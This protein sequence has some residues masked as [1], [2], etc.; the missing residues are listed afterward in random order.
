MGFK[1]I[2]VVILK[3]FTKRKVAFSRAFITSRY[4]PVF[5]GTNQQHLEVLGCKV[6]QSSSCCA[7]CLIL[8]VR[9]GT[10]KIG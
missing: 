7:S 1:C 2:V 8:V 10:L 6:Q 9:L 5:K 3:E 4:S